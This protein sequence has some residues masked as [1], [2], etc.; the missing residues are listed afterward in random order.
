MNVVLGGRDYLMT[1]R[2]E[3]GVGRFGK[4]PGVEFPEKGI[5]T[6]DGW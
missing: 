6:K 4:E 1:L 2:V 5:R 3:A